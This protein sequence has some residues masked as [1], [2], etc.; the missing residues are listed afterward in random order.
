M[1][2]IFSVIF[3]LIIITGYRANAQNQ[4]IN[5]D[6]LSLREVIGLVVTTHPSVKA[7][8]EAVN[9]SENGISLAKAGF[10]PDA[11]VTASFNNLG[12]VT[13]LTIPE[14][15]IIQLFPE[16]NYAAAVNF[17][18]NIYD[19]GR[20][21]QNI[22]FEKENK[23]LNEITSENLKQKLS[24]SA[25]NIYYSLVYLQAAVKIK[26]EQ[27]SALNEHL[28]NIEKLMAT[29]SATEYQSLSTKVRIS[30]IESQK[31]DLESASRSQQ[32]LLNSLIGNEAGAGVKV[33]NDFSADLP[34]VS[35]DS[36]LVYALSNRREILLNQSRASLAGIRYDIARLQN[37]PNISL[38]ASAGAKNG[39]M[40][41]LGQLR[42]NYVIG[43]GLRVPL[44]DAIK[45]KY[46]I[47]QARSAMTTVSYE[48][49]TTRR[50]ISSEVLEAEASV[51]AAEQK[52]SQFSLQLHQAE[53]AYSLAET[54]FRSGTITNLDLLDANTAV[55]ESRLLL[56]KAKIDYQASIYRLK[57]SLGQKIY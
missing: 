19:F 14:R 23:T 12:P 35:Q 32:A 48:S 55:S 34:P 6:S 44:L 21:K 13:K 5:N 51:S 15:G 22:E 37:M 11:D 1:D 2:K 16:N 30:N 28:T 25:V 29:G 42:P 18:Q 27:I 26:E 52:L 24:M 20:T 50:N 43:I 36:L 47:S 49:E 54:S 10:Y 31:V 7:A 41:E 39:Y 56:L 4:I 46:R 45:N 53:K 57:A 8:E 40:P 17:R 33:K 9:N 3:S 38:Q